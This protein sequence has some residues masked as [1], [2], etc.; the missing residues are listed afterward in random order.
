MMKIDV[1]VIDHTGEQNNIQVV[2]GANLRDTLIKHNLSPYTRLTQQFNCGGKGLC[3]TCGVAII[4]GEPAPTHWHD[5]AAKQFR[6]PRLS[7][8]ISVEAP[9]TVQLVP[10]IVWGKRLKQK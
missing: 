9:M 7:C 4:A 6:Y 1:I 10:K 5:K 8:Q 3:A 2:R